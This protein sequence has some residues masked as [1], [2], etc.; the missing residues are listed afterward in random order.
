MP[1]NGT[2]NFCFPCEMKLTREIKRTVKR[3]NDAIRRQTDYCRIHNIPLVERLDNKNMLA[4]KERILDK[5]SYLYSIHNHH[6]IKLSPYSTQCIWNEYHSRKEDT[7]FIKNINKVLTRFQLTYK[8]P[9]DNK[10][11]I[12]V[13]GV[14]LLNLNLDNQVLTIIASLKFQDLTV[15]NITLL[16]HLMYKRGKVTISEYVVDSIKDQKNNNICNGGA[17]SCICTKQENR[18]PI[19]RNMPAKSLQEYIHDSTAFTQRYKKYPFDA[20]ARYSLLEVS[21]PL[22]YDHSYPEQEITIIYQLLTADEMAS[23][24]KVK[25]I[26]DIST[27]GQYKLYVKDLNGL[28]VTSQSEHTRY[29]KKHKEFISKLS[30]ARDW[31]NKYIVQKDCSCI[32]GIGKRFFATYLKSV[33]LHYLMNNVKSNEITTREISYY[34][35][36]IIARR[37][38][39]LW[40]ILYELDMNIIHFNSA[41]HK[42]FGITKMKKEI[43]EEHSKLIERNNML[44]LAFMSIMTCIIAI[45]TL[46]K[47]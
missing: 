46:A 17:F 37:A 39:Y 18:V 44:F 12:Q 35:P 31:H 4:E 25:E 26:K 23:F 36:I 2:L 9:N 30:P 45:I 6:N 47:P 13:E 34:N 15:D 42:E 40:K 16:K 8:N 41:I 11:S 24:A 33:E 43:A 7:L 10:Q 29:V 21:E 28:I 20:R 5:L 14:L 38:K 1:Y 19:M 22:T 27:R 32:A 3:Y